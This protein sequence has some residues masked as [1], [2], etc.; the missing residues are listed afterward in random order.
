VPSGATGLTNSG[1]L[2]FGPE[3]DLFVIDN[4]EGRVKRFDGRSGSLVGTFISGLPTVQD[5]VF[6]PDGNLYVSF[7]NSD[8]IR[9]Y[10]GDTGAAIDT[11][12][13]PGSGGLDGPIG[14]AFGTDGDLFVASAFS[15]SVFRFDG[16]TGDFV[17]EFA[18]LPDSSV[19]T[20]LA[21]GPDGH[22]YVVSR[23]IGPGTGVLRFDGD[24]GAPLGVFIQPGAGGLR[25]LNTGMF[26]VHRD[27]ALLPVEG[28]PSG[29]FAK[30]FG[31]LS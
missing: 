16:L 18:T 4:L 29:C 28:A 13:T 22:L 8:Q 21:F 14:M 24:S 17:S 23:A 3:G 11:F 12:V 19:P 10:D 5:I 20:D 9:R 7:G 30:G 2:T 31:P 1:A 27:C 15:D 26:F 25:V 6:G